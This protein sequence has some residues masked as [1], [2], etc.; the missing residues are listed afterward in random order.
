M[1]HRSILF[2]LVCA[3]VCTAASTPEG[4]VPVRAERR[5]VREDAELITYFQRIP[6]ADGTTSEIPLLAV[7]D[8]TLGA[9]GSGSERLRQV[10]VFTY[11]R[12]NVAHRLSGAV[13]FLYARTPLPDGAA[14]EPAPVID[15]SA[16][17]RGIWKGFA[18]VAVQSEV[19]DPVGSIARLVFRSYSANMVEYRR[20]H[21]WQALD[22]LAAAP[23]SAG[24]AGLNEEQMEAIQG[25]LELS[26]RLF[27]GL[28]SDEYLQRAYAKNRTRRMETR[29]ANWDL[30]RQKAEENGLYFQPVSIAGLPESWAMLWINDA[31]AASARKFESQF[32]CIANPYGDTSL[33]SWTGYAETWWLDARGTPVDA[34]TAD[35]HP[36][37]MIPLALYALD[38]PRTPLL[39]ADMRRSGSAQRSEIAR[40]LVQDLTTGV[41]G[42]TG[43]GH[44]SYL[45]AKSVYSFVR[46]R[47]GVPMERAARLRAY[48]QVQ[49]ALAADDT[50]S[51][52]LRH[53]LAKR[54][55]ALNTNP[56]EHDSDREARAANEQYAA[57]LK[58]VDSPTGL[59]RDLATGRERE[60][61]AAK[62]G[63][64]RRT[65]FQLGTVASA[66]IYRHR[67]TLD[68]VE[69]STLAARR[70]ENSASRREDMLPPEPP[71][72]VAGGGL[73]GGDGAQ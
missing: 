54:V 67:E 46:A 5:P 47:H 27:G 65:L 26:G 32:L 21:V 60:L 15:M 14:S 64:G 20:S 72:V 36:A 73:A 3:A 37:R 45:A 2:A 28:V 6:A 16:P 59:S 69:L 12:P 8:D 1:L 17:A 24:D 56:M 63:L 38:H 13:P 43:Y 9:A 7:L 52:A 29:A 68:P 30:L 39:L 34:G 25:R 10:W 35:A 61:S 71:P 22:V 57:F 66:G 4:F 49:H 18:S 53:E 62:H 51:P 31:E 11:R 23:I 42:W 19:L 33:K 50:L 55:D 41:L 44:W 40:R 48:V 70:R 58:Y